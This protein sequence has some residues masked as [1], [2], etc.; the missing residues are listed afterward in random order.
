MNIKTNTQIP[1]QEIKPVKTQNQPVSNTLEQK[2]ESKTISSDT[3]QIKDIKGKLG[4]CPFPIFGPCEPPVV[5][6]LPSPKPPTPSPSPKPEPPSPKPPACNPKTGNC[7]Q[8]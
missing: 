4:P 3:F 7:I 8:P 1:R 6:E 2:I 5:P